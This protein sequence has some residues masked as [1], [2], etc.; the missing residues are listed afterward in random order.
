[1]GD[2]IGRIWDG[3]RWR[4]DRS[5]IRAYADATDDANPRYRTDRPVAPPMFHVRPLIGLLERLVADPEL[6][7][8]RLRLVHGEHAVSFPTLLR[9]DDVLALSAELRSLD[10]KPSGRVATFV[11]RGDVD[12]RPALEGTTTFFVRAAAPPPKDPS[13]RPAAPPAPLAPDRLVQQRVTDD[14]S[15]RYAAASGDHNPIHVDD[16]VAK[17]AGLP[18]TILHG[19]CSMAFAARDLVD[20]LGG[21]DPERLRSIGL[22]WARPVLPGS[23]LTLKVWGAA[24]GPVTFAVDGPDGKA[25]ITDG[26]AE[27]C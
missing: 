9:H 17:A 7:F 2:A 11:I 3:G 1:V 5:E 25:V 22:R 4:C 16:A 21:G 15:I 10:E 8:D 19:L 6:A 13:A 26:R 27:L 14:Q 20:Q 12:G 23:T 18:G 24:P